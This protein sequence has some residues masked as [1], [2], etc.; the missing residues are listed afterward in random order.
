MS[1]N[2]FEE[3][4][5]FIAMKSALFVIRSTATQIA[6]CFLDVRGSIVCSPHEYKYLTSWTLTY[7]MHYSDIDVGK[8]LELRNKGDMI[9]E[10]RD[11]NMIIHNY[12]GCASCICARY[13]Y[14]MD[15]T[16]YVE[17]YQESLT[18]LDIGHNV[19]NKEA[20][21]ALMR[22]EKQALGVPTEGADEGKAKNLTKSCKNN[23][24]SKIFPN[25]TGI[26]ELETSGRGLDRVNGYGT[27]FARNWHF[28]HISLVHAPI[29]TIQNVLES[30]KM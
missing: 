1:A 6:S 8:L 16:T 13:E 22:I 23:H 19:L 25:P 26:P 12:S 17:K 15:C 18:L 14:K 28:E 5:S 9:M 21:N 24:N 20:I 29:N 4:V 3:K 10:S 2:T 27:G 30:Q 11:G 7:N